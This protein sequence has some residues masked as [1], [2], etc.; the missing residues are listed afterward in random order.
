MGYSKILT[1]ATMTDTAPE[2]FDFRKILSGT[3]RLGR[4]T[5]RFPKLTESPN[6]PDFANYLR[7]ADYVI[8][9]HCVGR[10]PTP[11]AEAMQA[12]KPH[13]LSTKEARE[14]WDHYLH[15]LHILAHA[16]ASTYQG[17]TLGEKEIAMHHARILR[18]W[19]EIGDE[20]G[21]F[22][23]TRYDLSERYPLPNHDAFSS[24]ITWFYEDAMATMEAPPD[25][26]QPKAP[27]K[28]GELRRGS[29]KI[30]QLMEEAAAARRAEPP[31]ARTLLTVK[32]PKPEAERVKL[33]IA[34]VEGPASD[35]SWYETF[36]NAA[37]T[38]SRHLRTVLTDELRAVLLSA[39]DNAGQQ[40]DRALTHY[41]SV[42]CHN[43]HHPEDVKD[44]AAAFG[45]LNDAVQHLITQL[46]GD[47]DRLPDRE[48][49]STL[50]EGMKRAALAALNTPD[51]GHNSPSKRNGG[52][53]GGFPGGRR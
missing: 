27:T 46:P 38:R 15:E 16:L 5:R 11:W 25:T 30:R 28:A 45:A 48:Q 4:H 20:I 3:D 21:Y 7:A 12:Y 50:E 43:F 1:G 19:E 47:K 8:A 34:M 29:T 23:A 9:Q 51:I 53:P 18:A 44:D 22:A 31:P 35:L 26:I 13:A 42:V 52:G 33:A 14:H 24:A 40:V 6:T 17:R 37:T 49:F 39:L 41:A 36:L 2:P 10:A 32:R